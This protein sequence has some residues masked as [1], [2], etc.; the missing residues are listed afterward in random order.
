MEQ[1]D[2]LIDRKIS[3]T[4]TASEANQLDQ[5]ILNQ[6]EIVKD[7][8]E[9][10]EIS[11]AIRYAGNEELRTSL[12]QIHSEEFPQKS[13]SKL[14]SLKT[15][16]SIA[17]IFIL[18]I[19]G[20]MFLMNDQLNDISGNQ[21]YSSYYKPY[22]ASFQSRGELSDID[23]E[24]FKTAYSNDN[25]NEALR[26]VSD[27]TD[28][29]NIK[30]NEILLAM[31]ISALEEGELGLAKNYL[32]IIIDRNDYYYKDHGKWYIALAYLKEENTA[33]A[34]E[35]LNELTTDKQ[36]D[37]NQEATELLSKIK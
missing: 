4:I 11:K 1:L 8:E 18:G 24:K 31:G 36:A 29:K 25:F 30:D 7:I 5:L 9:R 12:K 2:Y 33:K 27:E 17:A 14:I 23:Y 20:Y 32:Q 16:L 10:L 13:K 37:H 34:I 3:G 28:I 22:K 19:A 26:I 35:F 6:P 21:A 15:I